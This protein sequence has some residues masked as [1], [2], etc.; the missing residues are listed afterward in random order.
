MPR[1]TTDHGL[2]TTDYGLM[3]RYFIG[4]SSGSSLFGVDAALVSVEG[5]GGDA[6]FTLEHFLQLPHSQELRELLWNVT[7]SKAPELGHV[8]TLHRVLGETY[9]LAVRQLLDLSRRTEREILCIGCPG[10]SLWHAPD[11][12]FPATMQLGMMSVVAERTGLTTLSD[13]AGRDLVLGGQGAP[14]SDR[15]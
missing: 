4:L 10:Q 7:T 2:P 8:A 14:L 5:V 9:A 11:G 12:R 6:R 3:T 15:K 13:F 1:R